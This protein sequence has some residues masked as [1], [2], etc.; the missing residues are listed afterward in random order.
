MQRGKRILKWVLIALLAVM[1]LLAVLVGPQAYRAVY[2]SHDHDRVAPTVPATFPK[3]AVLIFSKTN[4]FRHNEAIE[5]QSLMFSKLAEQQS[6]SVYATEN[7]AVFTPE[8]LARFQVVVW[9]NSSGDTLSRAQQA[10]LRE[11]IEAGGGFVGIHASGGDFAYD[12]K[13]YV[14]ELLGA[15]FIGHS[16]W[17]H[18]TPAKVQVEAAD[19]PAMANLPGVWTRSDEWYSFDRTVRGKPGFRVLATLDEASY[20]RGGPGSAKLAMGKDHPIIWSRCLAKGR[21]LYSALG[22]TAESYAEPHFR[23]LVSNAVTWAMRR[24]ACV[25]G[26]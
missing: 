10:H 25:S 13:W 19:H 18:I 9:A 12:W 22:H 6:W 21:V 24:D 14:E 2:F 26:L 20:E 7:G 5:A 16:L 11:W 8:L 4:G 15:Q 23:T 17:P 3:P 1:A